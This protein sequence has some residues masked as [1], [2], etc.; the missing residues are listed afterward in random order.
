MMRVETQISLCLKNFISG[1]TEQ[2]K[3]MSYQLP[4]F[5]QWEK[6]WV[7]IGF[8]VFL[9]NIMLKQLRILPKWLLDVK[10]DLGLCFELPRSLEAAEAIRGRGQIW[11]PEVRASHLSI[12]YGGLGGSRS[13]EQPR[14]ASDL[15]S[16]R[17]ASRLDPHIWY[18]NDLPWPQ[19]VKFDLDLGWPRR[20]RV[21]SE[22]QNRGRG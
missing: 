22:V 4:P 20:P 18:S 8:L 1:T 9:K 16:G 5:T 21:T 7:K 6:D 12:I 3:A 14:A 15:K 19:D 11:H 13:L 2:G 10:F 17:M